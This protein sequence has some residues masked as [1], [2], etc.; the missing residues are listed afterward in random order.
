MAAT[1]DLVKTYFEIEKPFDPQ[2]AYTNDFLST[3][4]KMTA[5]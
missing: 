4:I 5:Q 2:S 3:D 1:Y